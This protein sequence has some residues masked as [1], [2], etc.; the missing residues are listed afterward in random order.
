[1]KRDVAALLADMQDHLALIESFMIGV[2][3]GAFQRDQKTQFAVL[4]ALEVVGEAAKRLPPDVHARF[5]DV[6]WRQIIG[7][8][9]IIAHD[10]L[11]LSLSMIYET[12]TGFAPRLAIRVNEMI[13]DMAQESRA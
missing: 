4:R 8:R 13:H 2:D 3:W 11:G 9:N 12:A 10:Y 5:S 7:M 6:P 1:M